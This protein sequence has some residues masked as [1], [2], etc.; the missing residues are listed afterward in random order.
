MSELRVRLTGEDA[1]LGEVP[2]ADVARLILD[3]QRAMARAA[4]VIL[5]RPKTSTGRYEQVIASAVQLR[6]RGVEAGSVVPVLELPDRTP[7]EQEAALDLGDATLAEAALKALLE[8]AAPDSQAHPVI[9]EALLELADDMRVGE[10]YEAVSFQSSKIEGKRRS[11]VVDGGVRQ[12]LRQ[13]VEQG[14]AAAVRP[15]TVVGK[16]FEANFEKQTARLRA[17]TREVVEVRFDED[18]ADDIQAALRQ[19]TAL[20]GEV[21]YDPKTQLVRSVKLRRIVRGEQMILGLDTDDFW[22]EHTF[23][24]LIARHGTGAPVDPDDLYDAEAT[25]EERDAFMAALAELD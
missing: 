14:S 23:D 3:V 4:S 18:H 9:A 16:L 20:Q 6:L 22:R 19:R 5:R 11:A 15:E 2:A 17:P 24:D 1:A 7:E 21:A 10:K 13:H 12:R 8:A 25:Q